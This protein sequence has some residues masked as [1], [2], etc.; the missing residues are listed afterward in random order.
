MGLAVEVFV[1]RG[2]HALQLGREEVGDL[3]V[4]Q[5]EERA[6]DA[7]LRS[8]GL[9][10]WPLKNIS[11]LYG[12]SQFNVSLIKLTVRGK[13]AYWSNKRLTLAFPKGLSV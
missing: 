9:E 4:V 5:L 6:L 12:V 10:V 2:I 13:L 8:A 7:V 3:F 1:R 11:S